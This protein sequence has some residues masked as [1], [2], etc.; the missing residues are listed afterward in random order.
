MS[1][2]YTPPLSERIALTDL[3]ATFVDLAE[4][5]T[6]GS[7]VL[8]LVSML[9]LRTVKILPV[10]LSGV[11]VIDQS[12]ALQLIGS[13]HHSLELLD[14]FHI[15]NEDGPS[16][17]CCHEARTVAEDDLPSRTSTSR[18]A[19]VAVKRGFSAAYALPLRSQNFVVGALNLLT[20]QKLTER[21]LLIGQ[22]L[23]DATTIAFFQVDPQHD[24][25]IVARKIHIAVEARNALEQAKGILNQRH[26]ISMEQAFEVLQRVSEAHSID[27][28]QLASDVVNRSLSTA[29]ATTLES[30]IPRV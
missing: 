28:S 24:L 4:M 18:F 15:Q 1:A 14:L 2:E 21:E 29:L 16:L 23:A 25:E 12:N 9:S 11:L 13:S 5:M 30:S 19:D 27:L 8:D 22:A 10:D 17:T 20:R 3:G 6:Q 7:G 26:G